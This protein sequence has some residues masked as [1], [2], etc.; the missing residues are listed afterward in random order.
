M[1]KEGGEH[2]VAVADHLKRC[3]QHCGQA[4]ALSFILGQFPRFLLRDVSV[5]FAHYVHDFGNALLEPRVAEGVASLIERAGCKVKDGLVSIAKLARG[6]NLTKVF[7]RHG[8][9]AVDQVAPTIGQ[10]VVNATDKLVPS[11]VSVVI[12]RSRDS[13]EVTQGIGTK[14]LQEVLD[15]DDHPLGG[16]ELGPGHGQILRRDNF[17]GQL[18]RA[19]LSD[20]TLTGTF[21]TVA[22]QFSGPNLRVEGDVV[23]THE[24]VRDSIR[25]GPERAPRLWFSDAIGPFNGGG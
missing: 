14:F 8:D 25:V 9:S 20:R 3:P 22:Q 21:T 4:L 24:V 16:G 1:R 13:D 15:V 7:M 18:Q 10:L 6:G 2:G 23:F 11:K 19:E 5:G 12:F 17:G